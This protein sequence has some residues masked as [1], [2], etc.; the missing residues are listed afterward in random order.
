MDKQKSKIGII[1]SFR[2]F[3]KDVL[4]ISTRRQKCGKNKDN[5]ETIV[6]LAY[7]FLGWS[8]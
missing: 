4:Q 2:K 7:C 1:S 6:A 8:K 5:I 3:D